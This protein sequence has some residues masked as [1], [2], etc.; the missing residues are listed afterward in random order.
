MNHVNWQT[1]EA[2]LSDEVISEKT[3]GTPIGTI[4]HS[5]KRLKGKW[6]DWRT[7]RTKTKNGFRSVNVYKLNHDRV[8]AMLDAM[9]IA[10]DTRKERRQAIAA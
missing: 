2:Y 7:T 10:R 8:S 4:K 6:L 5:R 1:E 3:G 9:T